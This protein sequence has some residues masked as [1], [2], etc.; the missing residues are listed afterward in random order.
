M[1]IESTMIQSA[2]LR[3]RARSRSRGESVFRGSFGE[4]IAS[5]YSYPHKYLNSA[6]QVAAGAKSPM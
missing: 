3:S 4:D 5:F 1:A 2:A 6:R